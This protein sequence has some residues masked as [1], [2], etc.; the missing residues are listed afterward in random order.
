MENIQKSLSE[1]TEFVLR[2]GMGTMGRQIRV[3]SNFFEITKLPDMKIIHYDVTITPDVPPI[4]NRII[5]A[6]F[7]LL[8][9]WEI[10][11][12]YSMVN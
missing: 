6:E 1:L 8:E 3:R 7:T 10:F 11:V 4:L 9:H 5:F 2:P 12:Q